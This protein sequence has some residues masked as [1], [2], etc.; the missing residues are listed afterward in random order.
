MRK[1][2]VITRPEGPYAGAQ[3]LA[4]KLQARGF[5]PFELPILTCEPIE[6]P[7]ESL[8]LIQTTIAHGT[9]WVAF[10]SPTAVYAFKA[11]MERHFPDVQLAKRVALAAQGTGTAQALQECFGKAPEFIPSVFVAEEFARE[12]AERI[13]NEQVLVPQSADGRDVLVPSLVKLGKRAASFHLYC[14]RRKEVQP[15]IRRAFS[16]LDNDTTFVVFMSPSA[17]QAAVEEVGADLKSKR[18]ISVGP[19]TSNALRKAGL[20]VWREAGEHSED[21]VLAALEQGE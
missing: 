7:G 6:P 17:V 3:K 5:E 2:V 16:A 4:R 13:G 14:L 1:T 20:S 18:V 15:E 9:S 10:L 21:G 11:V 19:I 12:F 8:R